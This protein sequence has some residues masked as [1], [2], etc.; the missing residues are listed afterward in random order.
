M[1]ANIY[2]YL[3]RGEWRYMKVVVI[4]MPNFLG[5]VLK[6]ILRMNSE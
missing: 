4:K 3:S 2:D 6:K 5:K 1:E